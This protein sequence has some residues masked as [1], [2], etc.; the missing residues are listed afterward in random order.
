MKKLLAVVLSLSLVMLAPFP[1]RAEGSPDTSAQAFV[2]YCVENGEIILSKNESKAMKPAS[3]T[4]LMTVLLTLEEAAKNDRVVTFTG[5]MT[6]EG[7]SMY[8]KV[9]EK[10][11]LSDLAAGMMMCSG[12]DA[13]NAAA[14]AIGGSKERF[15]ELMNRR[16]EQIGMAHTHFVTPSG[17]DDDRHYTTAYDLALLMAEGLHNKDFADLTF[18]KSAGVAFAEPAGKQ[19]TYSNHN[20]LLRMY[21]DC[22]G[23]KT[24][25]TSEAGRCLVSA[26][27]RGGVTLVCVTLDD[28]DDWNDH[29]ALYDYG[30]EHRGAY[31]SSDGSLCLEVPCVG[32][33]QDSLTVMGDSDATLIVPHG[34]EDEVRR[35]ICLDSFVYA[36]VSEDEAL[37]HIDYTLDGRLLKS[38]ALRA[39]EDVPRQKIKHKLLRRIK[40]SFTY[41]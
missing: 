21:D 1:A 40:E 24:G 28:K 16:A 35:T 7:S 29:I 25:Y 22:I 14:V 38:I 32:G 9:G 4:K 34:K 36:P 27:R 30:F 12:N 13:A 17:L 3:T 31:H 23:G 20:R 6:A 8:L 2:L 37:G 26:A 11:R 5:E 33:E 39:T 41:G 18:Q 19:I 10:V 15:A